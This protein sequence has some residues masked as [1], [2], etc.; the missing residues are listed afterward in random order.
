M[1]I[2]TT[3]LYNYPNMKIIELFI[4]GMMLA[5][6]IS[7]DEKIIADED[8]SESGAINTLTV[9]VE[10]GNSLSSKIDEVKVIVLPFLYSDKYHIQVENF[11]YPEG[12]EIAKAN[13]A[14]GGFSVD[15]PKNINSLFMYPLL[16][17]WN[18]QLDIDKYPARSNTFLITPQNVKY[19]AACIV[20]YKSGKQVGAFWRGIYYI[21]YSCRECSEKFGI[22]HRKILGLEYYESDCSIGLFERYIV[23]NGSTKLTEISFQKGWNVVSSWLEDISDTLSTYELQSEWKWYYVEYG[24]ESD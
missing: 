7:C 20:A 3:T 18:D 23:K 5:S 8:D 6:L 11:K 22:Y 13:F 1:I 12:E 24:E 10:N 14:N 4:I 16:Q 15:L 21:K 19:T 2:Y 17:Q 9:Q